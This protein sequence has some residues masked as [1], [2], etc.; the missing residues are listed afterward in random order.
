MILKFRIPILISKLMFV[1]IS[2]AIKALFSL[3]GLDWSAGDLKALII[4]PPGDVNAGLSSV[5]GGGQW[6]QV[7][8][9]GSWERREGTLTG[10]IDKT[11]S[12]VTSSLLT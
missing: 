11:I 10:L 9:G 5:S 8:A 4:F 1:F 12:K 3:A 7:V 6:R 2:P